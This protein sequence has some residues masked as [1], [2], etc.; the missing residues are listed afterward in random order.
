VSALK[1]ELLTETGNV[2]SCND[3]DYIDNII[4]GLQHSLHAGFHCTAAYHIGS[5]QC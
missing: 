5:V 3:S 1:T 2:M 4:I